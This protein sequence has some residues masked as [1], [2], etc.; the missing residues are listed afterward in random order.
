MKELFKVTT[1]QVELSE[2]TFNQY[3]GCRNCPNSEGP[4]WRGYDNGYMYWCRRHH[5]W[6]DKDSGCTNHS[7]IIR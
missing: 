3:I 4:Y 2:D 6:E 5:Q 1:K 7:T